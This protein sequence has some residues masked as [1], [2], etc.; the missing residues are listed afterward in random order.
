MMNKVEGFEIAG[1]TTPVNLRR[2]PILNAFVHDVT[3]EDLIARFREGSG[4]I[5]TL[6]VD[7]LVKMPRDHEFHGVLE[8]FD[9]VTCDS[10]VMT[11]ALRFL[12]TP[13]RARASGSDFLPMFYMDR[14]D[15]PETRIFIM[16]GAPGVAERAA[17]RINA[18][19]GRGI[20]VGTDSPAFDYE[21]D[22]AEVDRMIGTVNASGA[23]V[24]VVG[25]GGGR[26]E[27]FILRYRH[28]M[29]GVR[30]WLPLGGAIDY[31][32]GD[33]PRPPAWVTNA[34]FEWLYRVIRQPRARFRRYF[35]DDTPF[36]WLVLKQR[37]GLYRDPLA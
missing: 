23:T 2:V 6:H 30:L 4:T 21:A 32:S 1:Q 31:E 11:F 14:K 35:I 28:Q 37:F 8:K 5:L 33:L 22:P 12:G 34:G 36:L 15:D 20:V 19:A 25:L 3:L 26:Q 16:G 29:P 9:V 10:Q 27:K 7:M 18:R 24:C 13:I 17:A